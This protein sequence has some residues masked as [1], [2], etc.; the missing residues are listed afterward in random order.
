MRGLP[1]APRRVGPRGPESEPPTPWCAA[2]LPCSLGET[3]TPPGELGRS[4]DSDTIH[5][6]SILMEGLQLLRERGGGAKVR[7]VRRNR[8]DLSGR[9]KRCWNDWR[10]PP[11]RMVGREGEGVQVAR[12]RGLSAWRASARRMDPRGLI[13]GAG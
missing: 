5:G 3:R 10:W 2:A 7:V 6:A 12:A 4:Q 9:C 8:R 11:D 1:A 13:Y